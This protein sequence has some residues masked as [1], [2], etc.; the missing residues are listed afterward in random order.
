MV[1]VPV[2]PLLVVR[3]PPLAPLRRRR[4]R[5]PRLR[6]R[7][8]HRQLRVREVPER[9]QAEHGAAASGRG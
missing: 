9:G 3:R 8:V 4:L 7:Q 5:S 6:L 1:L 2:P